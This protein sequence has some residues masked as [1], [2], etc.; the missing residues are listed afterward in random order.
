MTQELRSQLESV[1][2]NAQSAINTSQLAEQL[3]SV[4]VQ[5][6]LNNTSV[7][8]QLPNELQGGFEALT[9]AIDDVQNNIDLSFL[10]QVTTNL[11]QQIQPTIAQLTSQLPVAQDRLVRSH[12]SSTIQQALQSITG[13]D[14]ASNP[15]LLDVVITTPTPQAVA[16]NLINVVQASQAEIETVLQQL[17]QLDLPLVGGAFDLQHTTGHLASNLEALRALI[18]NETGATLSNVNQL[19]QLITNLQ[20]NTERVLS[21]LNTHGLQS[22]MENIV[23]EMFGPASSI[24]NQLATRNGIAANIPDRIRSQIMANIS[25]GSFTVAARLL[26]RFSDVDVDDIRSA[27]ENIDTTLFNNIVRPSAAVT[28]QSNATD[29]R[30]L[31]NNWQG[32]DTD[33]STYSIVHTKEELESELR[34]VDR[35]ITEVVVHWTNTGLNQ[36]M[37]A[38]DIANQMSQLYGIAMPYHY[39]ITRD[40]NIQRGRPA[41]Q[42]LSDI[43]LPN[44]HNVRSIH[45]AFVGGVNRP[46]GRTTT[47]EDIE[48]YRSRQSFTARQ[49]DAFRR[50]VDASLR[51]YPG[52]QF[53]GHRDI[54]RT[55]MDPGFDVRAYVQSTFRS[56]SF[57]D[58][59]LSQQPFTREDIAVAQQAAVGE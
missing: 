44:A 57:F 18:G 21:V 39:V 16:H 45:V 33:P 23:E 52:M 6:Q 47:M 55:Q 9:T 22:I 28:G 54:D 19:Q 27:L 24:I 46:I 34:G 41:D 17:V 31:A 51:A 29:L 58:E 30:R 8:G 42:D 43:T 1:F 5:H 10:D 40:G 4:V 3:A 2:R 13:T 36:N 38:A 20:T 50:L 32:V 37:T 48:S 35:E 49:W 25:S 56:R 14:S 26:S 59:P 7:L 15:G 53:L 12:D 11:Q